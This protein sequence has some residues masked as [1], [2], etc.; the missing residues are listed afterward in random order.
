MKNIIDENENKTQVFMIIS[1]SF[2]TQSDHQNDLFSYFRTSYIYKNCLIIAVK[3]RF[4]QQ[5][6]NYFID[7]RVTLHFNSR[8]TVRSHEKTGCQN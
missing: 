5:L 2:E 3:N 6:I 1:L 8:A 7:Q 4:E